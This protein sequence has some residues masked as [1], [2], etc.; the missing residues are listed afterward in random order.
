MKRIMIILVLI[1]AIPSAL[2]VDESC[3]AEMSNWCFGECCDDGCDCECN[4]ETE[5]CK[6]VC[7]DP[8]PRIEGGGKDHSLNIHRV[9]DYTLRKN[10]DNKLELIVENDGDYDEENVLV[11][12]ADCPD[13][14]QCSE[15]EISELSEGE[16]QTVEI[17]LSVSE[18]TRLGNIKLRA[19]AESD[20]DEENR[21]IYAEVLPE[22]HGSSDCPVGVDCVDSVCKCVE[23]WVCTWSECINN[24]KTKECKDAN[25]CGTTGHKPAAETEACEIPKPEPKPEEP[26]GD[27][28]NGDSGNP[29]PMGGITGQA[30]GGGSGTGGNSGFWAW[31]IGL[32]S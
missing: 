28:S 12:V 6:C 1:M 2:A 5:V 31:L 26:K 27:K 24:E 16:E 9:Y 29:D 18:D 4:E 25:D 23:N 8:A 13:N 21:Y 30:T 10:Q 17:V 32:F 7:P 14:W 3:H 22:C 20:G 19:Y 11:T 15:K